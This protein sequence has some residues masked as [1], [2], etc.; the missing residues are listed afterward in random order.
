M[1][2]YV[3]ISDIFGLLLARPDIYD[4]YTYVSS[5]YNNPFSDTEQV[6]IDILVRRK[7]VL[8]SNLLSVHVEYQIKRQIIYCKHVLSTE[9]RVNLQLYC[10]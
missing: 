4:S 1:Y 5:G 7:L 3:L 2:M 9:E 6:T 10:R 8:E